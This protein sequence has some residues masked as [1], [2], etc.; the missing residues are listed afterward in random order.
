MGRMGA[1]EGVGGGVGKDICMYPG[2][3]VVLYFIA[4]IF[5]MEDSRSLA[6]N[7]M[8]ICL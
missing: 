7:V 8:R 2:W 5:D 4:E 1:S 3:V 6:G